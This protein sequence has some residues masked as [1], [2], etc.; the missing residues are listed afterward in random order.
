MTDIL[1]GRDD[2]LFRAGIAES[3]G[4]SVN[5]FPSTLPGG[6]NS[7]AYQDVYDSL[8][9]NTSCMSTLDSGASLSCLRSLPFSELNAALNTSADGFGPFVP[10]IDNDFIATYPSVQL[11]S[12]NFVPVSLL[13]G[14]NTDEGTSFGI[15]YGP[16]S[17][18]VNSDAEWLDTLNSTNIAPDSQ[19]AAII[20]Y[21]YPNIQG[22][23]IPNLATFPWVI[24]ADSDFAAA[25]GFQFR[26]LTSYF[27]DVVVIAPR[28]ATNQA[29]SAYAVPSYS[30]RFD[31]VVN[32][33]L[34]CIGSTHFQ[35]VVF[36]FNNINGEGYATNPFGNMTADDE[37]KF[38]GLANLMSRSWVSFIVDGDPNNNGVDGAASWPVYNS[39]EGGG[40]GIN[41]VFTVNGSSYIEWDSFRGEGIA[42]INENAL[43]VYGQ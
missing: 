14:A 36:A 7:T 30:Y 24:P 29:W 20:S 16:N 18:G 31:V 23:G 17:T 25:M 19:T 42:F 6:Y 21:L 2:N 10:I 28:R 41:M 5:F 34:T 26:R 43:S 40:L 39:T 4:P 1:P 33:V 3:G 13:I 38:V 8:V 37:K 22:L 27:G 9:S 11:A 15:N 32:G 12:G 35:E